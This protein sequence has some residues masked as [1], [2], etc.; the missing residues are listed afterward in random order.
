MHENASNDVYFVHKIG[1]ERCAHHDQHQRRVAR[2]GASDYRRGEANRP[3]PRGFAGPDRARERQASSTARWERGPVAFGAPAA[4]RAGVILVDTSVWI[5]HLRSGETRLVTALEGGRVLMHPYVLGELAC[6]NLENRDEV[7]K[8]LEDLPAAP[9]ATD[10]EVLALIERR[11]LMG[12]G[13]GYVD[14]HLLASAAL[15]DAGRLWTRDRRLATAATEMELAFD[16][17]G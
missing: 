17:E 12:R 7:L 13:I 11:A 6:G 15:S 10:P 3:D 1:E 9:T 4:S 16:A 8:L 14:V 5:D 2:G